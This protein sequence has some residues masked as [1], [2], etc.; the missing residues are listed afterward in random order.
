MI[1]L[2]QDV[3]RLLVLGAAV[4]LLA[5]ACARRSHVSASHGQ[6]DS[7][8]AHSAGDTEAIFSAIGA[9]LPSENVRYVVSRLQCRGLDPACVQFPP[10][11]IRWTATEEPLLRAL[12]HAA[13]ADLVPPD[14]IRSPP[15]PWNVRPEEP[16]GYLAWFRQPDLRV[17][18]AA[19]RVQLTC[20]RDAPDAGMA[21]LRELEYSLRREGSRW[22]IA[23][24]SLVR[25]T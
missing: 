17:D 21:Y 13:G 1:P 22:I 9:D 15:C 7:A 4:A 16:V 5:S 11:A 8:S 23:T 20:R 14:A 2:E 10:S 12:A 6:I 25:V 24:K 3:R 19:V 18:S